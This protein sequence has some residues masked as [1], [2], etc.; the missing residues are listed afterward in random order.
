MAEDKKGLAVFDL[1]MVLDRKARRI[2]HPGP[3]PL[4]RN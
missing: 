1:T 4:Q 3:G 2:G